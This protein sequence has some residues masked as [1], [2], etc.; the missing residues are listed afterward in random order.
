MTL[1]NLASLRERVYNRVGL[2]VGPGRRHQQDVLNDWINDALE[3]LDL[4]LTEA[5]H[6]QRLAR[7]VVPTVGVSTPLVY[8]WPANN[9]IPLPADFLEL[10]RASVVEATRT[11]ALEPYV[12]M[13]TDDYQGDLWAL[14]ALEVWQMPGRPRKYR[15]ARITDPEGTVRPI[16]QLLPKTDGVYQIELIYTPTPKRLLADEDT[17]D[18]FPGSVD[19]VVCQ[20]AM[21]LSEF[22]GVNEP[23]VYA[24]LMQR[25]DEAATVVRD[26]AGMQARAGVLS[27]STAPRRDNPYARGRWARR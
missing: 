9:F 8:G 27:V 21:S 12:E 2:I 26:R 6:P 19:Y 20:A 24:A 18:F 10:R 23:R 22:D 11:Y 17:Y 7:A 14:Y 25:R 16:L 13:D 1:L 5:G 15:V 3:Q 4:L